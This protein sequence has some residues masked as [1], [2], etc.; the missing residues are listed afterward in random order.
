MGLMAVTSSSFVCTDWIPLAPLNGW[1]NVGGAGKPPL[2]YKK[3]GP[4]VVFRGELTAP[5][6]P[7]GTNLCAIPNDILPQAQYVFGCAG[8]TILAVALPCNFRVK[9]NGFITLE[10]VT[11][12]STVSVSAIFYP[13]LV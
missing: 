5:A 2:S 7:A 4:C 9:P 8:L 13:V 12:L 1:A 11:A 6:L 3:M 10:G